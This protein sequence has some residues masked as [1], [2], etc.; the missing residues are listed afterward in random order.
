MGFKLCGHSTFFHNSYKKL[1][2][3]WY[4]NSQ[5]RASMKTTRIL[6]P[7]KIHYMCS[8]D[9]NGPPALALAKL[10][11]KLLLCYNEG[12]SIIELCQI[13]SMDHTMEWLIEHFILIG[14]QYGNEVSEVWWTIRW[15]TEIKGGSRHGNGKQGRLYP[16]DYQLSTPS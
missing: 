1:S 9:P 10:K 4:W 2:F 6:V 8:Q 5:V 12:F 15:G 7:H 11:C 16:F 13:S 3:R 14:Y